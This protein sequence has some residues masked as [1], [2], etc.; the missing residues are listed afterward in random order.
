[1]DVDLDHPAISGY[2]ARLEAAAAG[3]PAWRREELVAE[4]RSHLNEALLT[5]ADGD[6]A[7]VRSA[8]DRLGDPA[9]IVAAEGAPAP[10]AAPPATPAPPPYAG[11]PGY[12]WQ[13][14][15][16]PARGLGAGWGPIELVAVVGLAVGVLTGGIGLVVGI[17]CTWISDR[18]TTREKVVATV[19]SS[20]VI[21]LV[22]L[23]ALLLFGLGAGKSTSDEFGTP[24]LVGT[25]ET[26]PGG[27]P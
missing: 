17:I 19:G 14:A 18:W 21:L 2:L 23:P 24:T 6:D 10:D 12:G 27:T 3:L 9:D 11:G 26:N 4:I 20:M 15:P 7:A 16:S 22:V 8:V 25:V 5:A 13:P 1:M